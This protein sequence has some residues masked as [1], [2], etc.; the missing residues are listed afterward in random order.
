MH[1]N[2]SI[3]HKWWFLPP[4]ELMADPVL[5]ADG[6]S[7]ERAAIEA[8]LRSHDTSPITGEPLPNRNVV[9]N[10][11]L[12]KVITMLIRDSKLQ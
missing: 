6:H 7:Y 11:A 8:S 10:H 12:K 2:Y 1:Y 5:C 3:I 9:P 4:Q